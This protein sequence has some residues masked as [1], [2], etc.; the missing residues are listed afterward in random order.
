MV[1]PNKAVVLT[2]ALLLAIPA[3][4]TVNLSASSGVYYIYTNSPQY[5]ILP[6]SQ[7]V[8]PLP[9]N[10]CL[11]FAVLLNFTNYQTLLSITNKISNHEAGYL[12]PAEFQSE[13]YPPQ[14]Y[15]QSLISYFESYG[16][17]LT[18]DYGLILTFC[19]T[20]GEIEQ[21]LHTYINCYYYPYTDIYW[22]GKI[23]MENVGPFYYFSNNVT[24]SLPYNIGKYVIGI[25]GIDSFDPKAVSVIKSAWTVAMQ[26]A[27]SEE[28]LVSSVLVTPSA[29]AQ[30]FDFTQLYS[31]GYLGQGTTIAIEGVPEDYVCVNDIYQFWSQFSIVP[32]T[33]GLNVVYLGQI[34]SIFPSVEN[35][36]DA[37]WAGVF[38]P[39]STI[40]IVFSNGYVGGSQLLGYLLNYYY[41]YYYMVNYID[42]NVISI[43]VTVPESY[44]AAYYPAMLWMIHN[45]MM[46][47]VDEG[48]SVVAAAGDWGYESDYP[49]P[50]YQIE[51][52]NTIWYPESDPYVTSVGG[53]FVSAN[54]EG[55]I[56][57]ISGWDYSTGG[58][59]VVFPPQVFQATS[60]IPYTPSGNRA[61]PDIAFVSAGGF[62]IPEYG[63]G[64]PLIYFG[65]L[66]VW[67]GTSGAAPMTA[68]MI[69]LTGLR[70]GDLNTILYHISYSGQIYTPKG[71][72]QGMQAWIPITSGSNPLPAH[73]GWNYVTGP[74]TYNAYGMVY[75]LMLY[76]KVMS[77]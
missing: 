5:S 44:L 68:A 36:L 10:I 77:S 64:L 63:F 18:G 55:Q 8:A 20:V 61:Y 26:K 51:I 76:Y 54:Y 73:Y 34:V 23:G 2:L 33:G 32:R 35:E 43:S 59:S 69:A 25:V 7:F 15:V 24:P 65:Q 40:Y 28:P 11:E 74:G 45:I 56:V 12:T 46:Q 58:T 14:S 72:I 42:P 41:E 49:P 75:D 47:A 53:I 6:G 22:F 37:E 50:T 27:E 60:V 17:Q 67:F 38:A 70:L 71:I 9:Q 57:S 4:L 1:I 39:A 30:Y 62:N 48:I 13:F 66:Y 29:I 52:H 16:I 31:Q 21:A 3:L 19:G